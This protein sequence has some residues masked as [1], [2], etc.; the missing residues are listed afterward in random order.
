VAVSTWATKLG[1]SMSSPSSVSGTPTASLP[2]AP[3]LLAGYP[4]LTIVLSMFVR[5]K[6]D[7]WR[8]VWGWQIGR[9]VIGGII[10]DSILVRMGK[11]SQWHCTTVT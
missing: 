4:P 10:F 3:S 11:I 1:P 2:T 6:G 7:G 9:T 8:E 5:E